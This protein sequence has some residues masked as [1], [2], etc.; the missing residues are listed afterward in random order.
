[1][2]VFGIDQTGAALSD[3]RSKPL[4]AAELTFDLEYRLIDLNFI[5]IANLS[6]WISTLDQKIKNHIFIDCVF[7]LP[8]DLYKSK[9]ELEIRDWIQK[10]GAFNVNGKNYGLDVSEEFFKTL[11]SYYNL[12]N[13]THPK[14]T[15]ESALKSNSV[16]TT[17]PFQKN[18][19][20]GTFRIW[21]ELSFVLDQVLIWP[22]DAP[23]I[24]SSHV[25]LYEVYPSYFYFKLFNTKSRDIA[26]LQKI[27]AP[28]NLKLKDPDYADAF[29][30][31]LG[32]Y[33]CLQERN[34]WTNLNSKTKFEG[35]ILR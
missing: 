30:A 1:M 32:G 8:F 33:T 5:Q 31:G 3:T 17:R 2:K 13:L 29:I 14:R 4:K 12:E 7:G 15:V 19:Q 26:P 20:T 11:K 10:A 25:I 9:P 23:I 6:D 18:I 16:F 24:N 28:F 35:D 27:L 22:I 21:K 34:V